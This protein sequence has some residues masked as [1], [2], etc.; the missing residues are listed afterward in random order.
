MNSQQ[1]IELDSSDFK[2]KPFTNKRK[3]KV[4]CKEIIKENI[5]IFCISITL[6]LLL[7]ISHLILSNKRKLLTINEKNITNEEL[8]R[9]S[10][11]DSI[12]VTKSTLE[13]DIKNIED[14]IKFIEQESKGVDIE[15]KDKEEQID[16]LSRRQ[17][18]L[19]EDQKKLEIENLEL[20]LNIRFNRDQV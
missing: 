1:L 7:L 15:I 11:Y 17:K 16:L 5:F 10:Y 4:K 14:K 18:S 8:N 9:L 13:R 20:M 6:I 19:E 2:P 3:K 12:K